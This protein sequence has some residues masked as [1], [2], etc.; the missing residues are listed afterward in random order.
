[1][2][3]QFCKERQAAGVYVDCPDRARRNP[4]RAVAL[5]EH[6]IALDVEHPTYLTVLALAYFRSGQ[7]EKAVVTQRQALESPKF[8]PGY[9]EEAAAQLNEYER[10]LAAQNHGKAGHRNGTAFVRE[11]GLRRNQPEPV[12]DRMRGKREVIAR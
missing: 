8:P 5:I 9:R 2:K 11:E 3:I 7:L 12:S 10:A 1:M 4:E 6:A